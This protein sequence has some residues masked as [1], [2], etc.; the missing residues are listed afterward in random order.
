VQI[1]PLEGAPPLSVTADGGVAIATEERGAQ[2]GA[3]AHE[4]APSLA[5]V[6]SAVEAANSTLAAMNHSL[7]FSIDPDTKSVVVRLIDTQDNQ[8]IR[9]V[10]TQ[11]ML[12][13][14]KAI[15]ELQEGLLLRNRA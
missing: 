12:E 5:D 11:E 6:K 3:A 13:I 2:A 8:V 1:R 14:A 7:E 9:Q 10:P 15:G 4:A